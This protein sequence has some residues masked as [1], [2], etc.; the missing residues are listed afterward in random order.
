MPATSALEIEQLRRMMGDLVALSSLP[1][2]WAGGEPAQIAAG[3]ADALQD[4]LGLELVYLRLAHLPDDRPLV[5]A[6]LAGRPATRADLEA[7]ERLLAPHVTAPV[8][9]RQATLPPFPDDAALVATL[10][11]IGTDGVDGVLVVG[12]RQPGFPTELDNLRLSVCA[13]LAVSWTRQARLTAARRAA[14]TLQADQRQVL[15]LLAAGEPTSSVLAQVARLVEAHCQPGALAA[16]MLLD[17]DG[18]RA[19]GTRADGARLRLGAAPSLPATFTR[20]TEGL[21]IPP[22]LG[23]CGAAANHGEPV[24]IPDVASDPL[25]DG[26]RGPALAHGL[27]ACWS[28]PICAAEGRLLG[29]LAVYFREPRQPGAHDREIISLGTR[30]A[31]IAIEHAQAESERRRH[32]ER[33]ARLNQLGQAFAAERNFKT[34][35][36]AI[37]DAATDLIGAQFG[38]F[39]RNVTNESGEHLSLHT[40]S[41]APR[42][43]FEGFAPPRNT[44]VFGPTFHGLGTIR[45]DNIRADPRYGQMAPHHGMPPGHLPV[46]SYLAVPV[47]SRMGH[48]LGGLFFGHAEPARF[49]AADEQLMTGLAAQAAIALDNAQFY[50]AEQQA[51]EWL[52]ER[53]QARTAELL[54]SEARFHTLVDS[55]QDYAIFMLDLAGC[56]AS[57]N[58]GAERIKGYSAGEIMGQH[59]SRFYAPEDVA[60][61][62]PEASLA[63]ARATGHFEAEGWRVRKDGTRF[64]AN[65]VI[66]PVRDTSGTLTG[67]AKVTRDLTERKKIEDALRQSHEQLRRLSLRLE[68]VREEERRRIAREIHD[69][70][71]GTLTGLKMDVA[72]LRRLGSGLEAPGLAKLETF[73]QNIDQA[74]QT[75]RRIATDLRPAVLDDFG[76]LA[77]MEWQLGEF[78]QR[79]G[80]E[81]Q[82]AS[83]A[84]EAALDGDAAV[85][86]FRVFQESLTNIGRHAAATRVDVR[87]KV[88]REALAFEV[89]DNG[90]G[91]TPQELRSAKSL[92]LA[93]MRERL[94]LLGGELQLRGQPGQGTTV[95]V[96]VPLP[97]APV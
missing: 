33:L 63:V 86:V 32:A 59:F 5:A 69:E 36:Q 66:T 25:W 16:L 82:W 7:L 81:T 35:L 28:T 15:E 57:W 1:A 17:G 42:E 74:I 41:G 45:S 23:A 75:V 80:I 52:E 94:R 73:S 4:V 9:T 34:L 84:S 58:T 13:N 77:A 64:W 22:N 14:E 40:L 18:T 78:Q 11:P 48:V 6:R 31:A 56:I 49:S 60:Q 8:T 51:R 50:Q 55:V 87:V 10:V 90:R 39:F 76:L 43:A 93:G 85:A 72:Q 83:N 96:R 30:L 3:L 97:A 91:I 21:P 24:V 68:Q 71:G 89:I 62:K 20:A 2:V 92:G 61:G 53:V 19:D 95:A 29:T 44:P 27:R 54:H 79:A 65:V 70:L 67:F 46:T 88:S 38:A 37:T 47:V 12:S 26:L